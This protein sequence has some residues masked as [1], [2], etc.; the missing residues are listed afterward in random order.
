MKSGRAET[1]QAPKPAWLDTVVT[2]C[3]AFVGPVAV[4]CIAALA[5]LV[6]HILG[7]PEPGAARNRYVPDIRKAQQQHG[8]SGTVPLAEAIG[9]TAHP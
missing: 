1:D 2:R 3:L 5:H 9:R 4:I 6:R 8:L 7:Q